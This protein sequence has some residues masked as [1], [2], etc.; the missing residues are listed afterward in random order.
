MS[1]Q[2]SEIQLF[3]H[4]SGVESAPLVRG[5]D[6]SKSMLINILSSG[7]VKHPTPATFSFYQGRF[8]IPLQHPLLCL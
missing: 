8:Q 4:S 6:L 3:E 1:E 5:A 2:F 7:F